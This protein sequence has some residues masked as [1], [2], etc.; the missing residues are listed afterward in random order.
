MS[1][2]YLDKLPKE[3]NDLVYLARD[4]S[5]KN[6]VPVYLVGGVVRDLILGVKNLDLDIV[7]SGDGIKFARQFSLALN[8]RIVEHARFGTA[9]VMLPDN[10]KV[11]FATAR[12]EVYPEPAHLPQVS[13]GTLEDDLYRRDFTINAMAI[14][15]GEINF[16]KIIDFFSG[17]SDLNKKRIR[18]LHDAS[19]IDDPTRIL[20][21]VRFEKR[22]NFKIEPGTLQ[23]LKEAVDLEML[24]R[25]QPQRL[26]DEIILILKEREPLK[27]IRRIDELSGL[28]F[29]NRHLFLSQKVN[30]L[31]SSAQKEIIWFKKTYP[32]R[33]RLDT[34]L[35]YFLALMEPLSIKEVKAVCAKFVFGGGEEKRIINYKKFGRSPVKELSR[36]KIRPARIFALL[37][38]LSYEVIIILKAKYEA[39]VFKKHVRDFFAIYNGMRIMARGADLHKL[40]VAPGPDYQKIFATVL[41]AKLAGRVRTKE[42][43]LA[44]I[45]RLIRKK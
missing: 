16:G 13:A 37:E 22:Y 19:F 35:V 41:E 8:A 20:R 43:E 33:R 38:P 4:I 17:R 40:G 24:E 3:I 44:L 9:T 45:K 42:E 39:A 26:R 23:C 11:D 31:L 28:D 21:A 7:V 34:W 1:K 36:A 30:N 2:D 15:I 27:Y 10:I 32:E 6:H 25:V 14:G 12:K 18:I 29:I 5:A